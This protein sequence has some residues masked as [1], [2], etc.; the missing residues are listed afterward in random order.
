MYANKEQGCQTLEPS[1]CEDKINGNLKRTATKTKKENCYYV[2][3]CDMGYL[4]SAGMSG[5]VRFCDRPIDKIIHRFRT[6]Q[7]ASN[8]LDRYERV[9]GKIGFGIRCVENGRLL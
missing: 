3:K 5:I 7:S 6:E 8:Y 2:L 4:V 9:L 1:F